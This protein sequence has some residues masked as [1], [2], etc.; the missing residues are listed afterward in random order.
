[1]RIDAP[2]ITGSF[3]INSVTLPDVG[4]LATTGSNTFGGNQ[5]ING[6][7][8]ATGTTLVSGSAQVDVMSTT[9]IARLATTGSNTFQGIQTVNGNLIVT[10]SLTAQQY[11]IS[12]SVTYLTESFASGSHKFGDSLDDTHQFTGS[13]S[14][15]GSLGINIAAGANGT[16]FITAGIATSFFDV[17]GTRGISIYPSQGGTIHQ[18]TSDYIGTS[19]YPI[20]ITAR[21]VNSDLYVSSSG[22]IGMGI[23]TPIAN[24]DVVSAVTGTYASSTQQLVAR[25]YNLPSSLGSGTNSAFIS[26]QASP[27]GG[28]SNPVARIGVVAESY[29]S[30]NGS[31][32]V[33]T[34]GGSGV[35]EQL[36]VTSG[37]LLGVGTT[38]P[39]DIIDVRRNQN[40]TT[41]FYFRNTD[42]T[43]ASSRAYLNVIAGDATMSMLALHGGDTYLAGTL[44]RNMIFQ[45]NPSGN[46]N[47][48]INSSGILGINTS[49][50]S[51]QTNGIGM[52]I[53]SNTNQF[54]VLRLERVAGGGGG[55]T[56]TNWEWTIGSSGNL[57][58]QNQSDTYEPLSV[59]NTTGN[60]TFSNDVSMNQGAY[61]RRF[62][63]TNG[64]YEF[65]R[66]VGT[67][68][69]GL[70]AW[71][72]IRQFHD[73]VNWCNGGILVE[74]I[75]YSYSYSELDHAIYFARY[76]YS[77]NAAGVDTRMS[78]ITNRI[79][80]PYWNSAVSVDGRYYYRDLVM[81]TT[82]YHSYIIKM[83]TIMDPYPNSTGS[84]IAN[85]VYLF[86]Y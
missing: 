49:S 39:S 83:T 54:P 50:P 61:I 66:S 3:V 1:M 62:T 23:T 84:A 33:A 11:I 15:T 58:L 52:V 27:D 13:V 71:Q 25:F 77:G 35:V 21:G 44:G 4:G 18:I 16:K 41:N 10:G 82:S 43:N 22:F 7:I 2:A 31:F 75:C 51:L 85:Q 32:V 45:Q 29:G 42:T 17:A 37:G 46:V 12:S 78:P 86:G 26:L 67:G 8:V 76:G 72:M 55:K 5:I 19:Y 81:D 69:S 24:L 6:T 56:T 20:A 40:A 36:R 57:V 60:A 65:V 79:T 74:I 68:A 80:A 30:N 70:T 14:I 53:S 48:I 34:R 64:L 59:E 9:N 28:A 47:M 38:S 63:R 73:S